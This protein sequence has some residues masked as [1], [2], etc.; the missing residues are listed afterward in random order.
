[1]PLSKDDIR[2][3]H[4]AALHDLTDAQRAAFKRIN[5]AFLESRFNNHAAKD[6]MDGIF[7]AEAGERNRAEEEAAA[8]PKDTPPLGG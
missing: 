7:E 2:A 8:Q 1:M 6:M 3:E 4:E 5:R